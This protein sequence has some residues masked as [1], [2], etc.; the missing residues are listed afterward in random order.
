MVEGQWNI[1]SGLTLLHAKDH[2]LD[3]NLHALSTEFGYAE[4]TYLPKDNIHIGLKGS[5]YSRPFVDSDYQTR[6]PD[7]NKDPSLNDS[8]FVLSGHITYRPT[9]KLDLVL[10]GTNLLNHTDYSPNFGPSSGYD[11][12]KPGIQVSLVLTYRL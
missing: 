1:R 10:S 4:L 6:V 12:E 8:Y 7:E 11:Y 2:E 3:T 9:D 5:Y